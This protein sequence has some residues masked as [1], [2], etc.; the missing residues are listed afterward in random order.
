[1]IQYNLKLLNI[2]LEG[3]G[4]DTSLSLCCHPPSTYSVLGLA[5]HKVGLGSPHLIFLPLFSP[6]MSRSFDGHILGLLIVH[7]FRGCILAATWPLLGS[8]RLSN[9]TIMITTEVARILKV[10]QMLW[11]EVRINHSKLSNKSITL[12]QVESIA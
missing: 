2:I 6:S 9:S 8:L 7:I 12:L 5:L 1:M 10:F 11:E 3:L 4:E